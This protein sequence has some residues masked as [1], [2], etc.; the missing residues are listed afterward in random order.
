MRDGKQGERKT[1]RTVATFDN[2]HT[3]THGVFSVCAPGTV[4]L[5][6]FCVIIIVTSCRVMADTNSNHVS[7]HA[8]HE[9]DNSS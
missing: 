2:T 7:S 1:S 8:P 9:S 6:A 5:T 3:D 4:P